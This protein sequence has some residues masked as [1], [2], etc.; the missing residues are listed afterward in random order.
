MTV[1][2]E[3]LP[4]P[5]RGRPFIFPAIE[6]SRL[7]NGLDVWTVRH[8]QI[9]VVAFS[10]LV[11]RGAASD[12]PGKHGLAAMTADMLDAYRF[13]LERAEARR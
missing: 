10:L 9:P 5:P 6:K 3:R 4:Q 13:A 12:T 8:A 11:R 7:P 1:N 2:R